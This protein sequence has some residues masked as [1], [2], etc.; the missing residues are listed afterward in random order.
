[1]AQ[2]LGHADVTVTLRIYGNQDDR[3]AAQAMRQAEIT[4]FEEPPG[5]LGLGMEETARQLDEEHHEP[6]R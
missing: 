5:L 2:A 1:M 4:P 3:P 6:K